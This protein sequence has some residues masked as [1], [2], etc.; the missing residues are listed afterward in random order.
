MT[1]RTLCCASAAVPG[2]ELWSATS[3]RHYFRNEVRAYLYNLGLP[4]VSKVIT[5]E[6]FRLYLGCTKILI[7]HLLK[8]LQNLSQYALPK[9]EF[10]DLPGN[11]LS[12][13]ESVQALSSYNIYGDGL[14]WSTNKH[15]HGLWIYH[16]HYSS[17]GTSI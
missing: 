15:G 2:P 4:S 11:L 16:L 10:V 3:E 9:T 13:N 8:L 6:E 14:Y 12:S 7:G 17:H 5:Y 1:K